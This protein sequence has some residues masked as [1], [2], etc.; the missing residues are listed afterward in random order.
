MS[1]CIVDVMFDSVNDIHC[2]ISR[3]TKAEVEYGYLNN[4]SVRPTVFLFLPPEEE[5]EAGSGWVRGTEGGHLFF[6]C[7]DSIPFSSGSGGAVKLK[8]RIKKINSAKVVRK[9]LGHCSKGGVCLI[10]F[11][12]T[13]DAH[14]VIPVVVFIRRSSLPAH[15]RTVYSGV[16]SSV[17]YHLR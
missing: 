17:D 9:W 14:A 15:G 7:C 10:I 8:Q 4:P 1:G 12:C 11:S 6:L 2:L 3:V 5:G 13:L 16:T